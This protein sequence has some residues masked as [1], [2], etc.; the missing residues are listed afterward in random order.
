[1]SHAHK[2]RAA[3]LGAAM[4]GAGQAAAQV[5]ALPGFHVAPFGQAPAGVSNPDSIISVDGHIWVGYGNTAAPDGSHGTSNIIAYNQDGSVALNLVLT[6]HNDGLRFDPRMHKIWAVQN[7]DAI[8]NVVYIDPKSGSA[9]APV[10][11]KPVNG[12]G[13]DD[14]AFINGRIYVSASNPKLNAKGV[15]TRPA[16][17][18]LARVGNGYVP[19]TV[20]SGNSP[21]VNVVTHQAGVLNLTDPNSLTVTPDGNLLM[22]DQGDAQLIL[23]RL[24]GKPGPYI[25]Q[26][27]LVG[28]VQVD[29][30]AFATS[31]RGALY[32]ADTPAN[33]IYKVTSQRFRLGK[34]YSASTGVPASGTNPAVPAFVGETFL[35]SGAVVPVVSGLSAPHGLLFVPH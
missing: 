21:A 32:I 3:L 23:V 29:D 1:M 2:L 15:N 31:T 10:D 6:G 17:V 30:T 4:F 28:G 20:L 7:E 12:G 18:A 34:P 11:L 8:P 16:I 27:P 9:S 22:T 13:Y 5:T 25:S 33:T 24:N 14:E 19:E 35:D 26:I